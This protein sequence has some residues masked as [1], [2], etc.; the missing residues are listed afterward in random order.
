MTL[1]AGS[2]DQWRPVT[3]ETFRIGSPELNPVIKLNQLA[4]DVGA[5]YLLKST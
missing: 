1:V 3:S 5:W 4:I 2:K